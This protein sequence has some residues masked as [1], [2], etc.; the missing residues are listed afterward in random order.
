MILRVLLIATSLGL[1]GCAGGDDPAEAGTDIGSGGTTGDPVDP[2]DSTTAVSTSSSSSTTATPTT[3]STSTTDTESSSSSGAVTTE[4]GSSSTG[5]CE[6]STEG[7]AC[8]PASDPECGD[9]LICNDDDICEV[10]LCPEKKDEPNGDPFEPFLLTDLEDDDPAVL[11]ESQLSGDDDVDWFRYGCNDPLLG[12]SEPNVDIVVPEG[13]RACFFLDCVQ[14]GNPLFDCPDGTE[15]ETAPIDSL[16]GC[17]ATGSFSA[18][19]DPFNC[20]DS[21]EDALEVY[22]RIEDG[23]AEACSDYSFSYGC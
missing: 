7:C 4:T 3:A 22:V 5:S 19:V 13:T 11:Y 16:P 23:P 2:T 14:G 6:P 10:A 17:C 9:G 12:S 21:S 8:D 18:E 20:P 1:I 15:E